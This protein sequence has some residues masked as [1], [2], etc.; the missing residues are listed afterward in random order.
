MQHSRP[1]LPLDICFGIIDAV[2]GEDSEYRK[3]TLKACALTSRAWLPL[4]R[5]HLYR[6]VRQLQESLL[7]PFLRTIVASPELGRLVR[8]FGVHFENSI[9]LKDPRYQKRGRCSHANP[10]FTALHQALPHFTRLEALRFRSEDEFA[11]NKLLLFVGMFS[12]LKTV[13]D[14]EIE[15]FVFGSFCDLV[16]LVDPFVQLERLAM[17]GCNWVDLPIPRPLNVTNR[18]LLRT[19]EIGQNLYAHGLLHVCPSTVDTLSLGPPPY[20]ITRSEDDPEED[21][22]ALSRYTDLEVLSMK[23]LMSHPNRPCENE[24]WLGWIPEA[25]SHV[26]G[27][28]L[29]SFDMPLRMLAL[30]EEMGTLRALIDHSLLTRVDEILASGSFPNLCIVNVTLEAVQPPD[31]EVWEEEKEDLAADIIASFPK[32]PGAGIDVSA[33]VSVRTWRGSQWE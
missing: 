15:D 22:R 3:E 31:P 4:A 14:L 10:V 20:E 17:N 23:G 18:R 6:D 5:G 12:A 7:L 27:M 28:N 11:N 21:Y 24:H 25:L 13:T 16:A 29:R 26:R 33:S 19:L 1:K 32:C 8:Y 9:V 2:D 30:G